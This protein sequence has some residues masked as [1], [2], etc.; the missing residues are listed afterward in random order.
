MSGR[1]FWGKYANFSMT[2]LK[3]SY[4]NYTI[5]RYIH[6]YNLDF[7]F[8]NETYHNMLSMYIVLIYILIK[9]FV[10]LFQQI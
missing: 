9:N 2:P 10:S 4:Q 3:D 8:Y 1:D 7:Q 5:G 6:K